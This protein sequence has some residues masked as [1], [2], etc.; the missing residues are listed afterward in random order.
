MQEIPSTLTTE[1]ASPERAPISIVKAQKNS[2]QT[3][4]HI[5]DFVGL[6]PI[7]ILVLNSFR[8]TVLANNTSLSLF[9]VNDEGKLLGKRPGEILHCVHALEC[10]S[11]CGTTRFCSRCG[12]ANVILRSQEGI[13]LGDLCRV[14]VRDENEKLNAMDLEVWAEPYEVNDYVYSVF[15]MR[16]IEDRVRRRM[17]EKVFFHDVLNSV[18]SLHGFYDLVKLSEDD[19]SD[20]TNYCLSEMG[21]VIQR[22]QDEIECQKSLLSA[23]NGELTTKESLVDLGQFIEKNIKMC[24]TYKIASNKEIEFTELDE[25]IYLLTDE[26]I[27]SRIVLNMLKN[28]FEAIEEGEKVTVTLNEVDKNIQIAVHNAGNIPDSIKLQ[29]FK[30]SFSTK[31]QDRGL[32]TYSMKLFA[33]NYL[34]GK[35]EFESSEEK[36]TTFYL[37]LPLVSEN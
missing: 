31:G 8:Q 34:G 23:E 6:T 15:F 17:L 11:G 16:N 20:E 7:P 26:T 13:P 30:R 19:F 1:F 27:L 24:S 14:T 9:D 2:L 25:E 12:A 33:E 3:I 22:I 10:D 29:L 4:D 37:N 35:V 21:K 18:G 5:R 36:G 28:A 32:G